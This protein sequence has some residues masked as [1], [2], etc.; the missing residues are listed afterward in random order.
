MYNDGSDR[1]DNTESEYQQCIIICRE[2]AAN[3]S[4]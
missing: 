4:D 2:H 1:L 3:E